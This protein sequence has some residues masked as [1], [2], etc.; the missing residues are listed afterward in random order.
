[1]TVMTSWDL[2]DDL[3]SARGHGLRTRLRSPPAAPC[4]QRLTGISSAAAAAIGV[5]AIIAEAGGRVVLDAAA[6]ELHVCGLYRVLDMLGMTRG[7]GGNRRH[8]YHQA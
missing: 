5:P 4:Q 1:M 7:A 8:V 3:R 6:V 2:F